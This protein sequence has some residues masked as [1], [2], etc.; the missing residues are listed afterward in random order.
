[1]S[2]EINNPPKM[3]ASHVTE[4]TNVYFS[5]IYERLFGLF[6]SRLFIRM[7]ELTT[8]QHHIES[9]IIKIEINKHTDFPSAHKT[10]EKYAVTNFTSMEDAYL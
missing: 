8:S 10:S 4:I 2:S 1:M 5:M 7:L 9:R 3:F 6:K